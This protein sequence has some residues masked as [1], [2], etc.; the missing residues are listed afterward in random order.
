MPE[1][2]AQP[3]PTNPFPS[4]EAPAATAAAKTEQAPPAEPT[5]PGPN[6][7]ELVNIEALDAEVKQPQFPPTGTPAE[8]EAGPEPPGNSPPQ[9][10]EPEPEPTAATE[11][12]PAEP[13]DR[14]DWGILDTELG[15]L[16]DVEE[17]KLDDYY[18]N[19]KPE[20]IRELPVVAKQILHNIRRHHKMELAEIGKEFEGVRNEIDEAWDDLKR[21]E[22]EFAQRQAEFAAV[23][24]S[25][26]V[27]KHMK[28]PEGELPDPYTEEGLQARIDKGVTERIKGIFDPFK[29]EAESL[30]RQAAYRDFVETHPEMRDPTFQDRVSTL[31]R[32]RKDT[33]RPITTQDAYRLVKLEDIEAEQQRIMSQQQAARAS[34][35]RHVART[36]SS[37]APAAHEIPPE[38]KKD[39]VELYNWLRANPEAKA[40]IDSSR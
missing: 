31:V 16:D 19:I 9:V 20:H 38:A 36:T 4:T 6:E 3:E 15:E 18:K 29:Q 13:E 40:R 11:E 24:D 27:Q 33:G 35:A 2:T 28:A 1:E 32:E 14:P 12:P 17:L 25:P 8:Q 26:E 22:T 34:S 21:R 37:G 23:L 10:K 7:S 39:I 5:T 30:R